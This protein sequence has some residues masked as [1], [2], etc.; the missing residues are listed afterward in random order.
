MAWFG[1]L[2]LGD[3][4]PTRIEDWRRQLDA[5]WRRQGASVVFTVRNASGLTA[6]VDRCS[7]LFDR[8]RGGYR[9]AGQDAAIFQ[10]WA[11][12]CLAVR[13]VLQARPASRSY[14]GPLNFD[15][16]TVRRLPPQLAPSISTDDARV[17]ADAVRRHQAL[18]ALLARAG[19]GMRV[20]GQG[21]RAALV[22]QG[23]RLQLAL[24][25]RA[26]FDGDGIEDVL[27]RARYRLDGGDYQA[28][29]LFVVSRLA[30][31]GP[32]RLIRT[33]DANRLPD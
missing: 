29:R 25:A 30:A 22:G 11:A 28:I 26:D 33:F 32:L 2:H 16:A 12:Q 8:V 24:L 5:P 23:G 31:G 1:D 4:R 20:S 21:R 3:A 19:R 7:V 6:E 13:Q 27:I 14:L 10:G 9:P 17:L 15:A 18:G